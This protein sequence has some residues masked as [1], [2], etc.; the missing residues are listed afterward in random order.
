MQVHEGTDESSVLGIN[1]R[2]T[3][4]VFV[5]NEHGKEGHQIRKHTHEN[6]LFIVYFA[7]A[8]FK[9]KV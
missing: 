2:S 5:R 1:V 6:P 7:F 9:Q 4:C 8:L 3:A